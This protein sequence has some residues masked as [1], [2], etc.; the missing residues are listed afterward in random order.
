[1]II[2]SVSI[3]ESSAIVFAHGEAANT[4]KTSNRSPAC[5]QQGE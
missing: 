5:I 4:T 3:T 2:D 1:M